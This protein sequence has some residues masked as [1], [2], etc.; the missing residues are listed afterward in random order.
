MT[1]SGDHRDSN[2]TVISLPKSVGALHGLLIVLM[3][4]LSAAAPNTVLEF[5]DFPHLPKTNDYLTSA[6]AQFERTHSGVRIHYTRLPWQDG[7]QKL[8]LS[9]LSGQPP[10]VCGQVSTGLP[11]FIAQ[12][13]LEPLETFLQNEVDDF[14]PDYLDAVSHNGHIYA[15]PW[16]KACYVMLLNLDLFEQFG[17][18]PPVDGRWTWDEFLA[19]MKA[20]TRSSASTTTIT[21]GTQPMFYGLVTNLGPMEYEAYSIIFNFGGR[22]LAED[23]FGK[24][25]SAVT[26]PA[27]RRGLQNLQDLEFVYHV[28]APGIGAMTQEQ[29]WNLWRDSRTCACTIQ[30]AWCVTAVERANEANEATNRRKAAAGRTSEMEKPIKWMIAAPPS[31]DA[32][33]TPV[34]GSSGLG[35]YVVF[36]QSDAERK[37]LAAEFALFLV[38]GEGQKVLRYENVYPSRK[39]SG[40]P[41]ADDPRLESVF[42]LF[43]AAIMSPL[44]PGGERIDRVLQ[45]EIQKAVLTDSATGRP[46]ATVEQATAAAESK[47]QA[48]LERAHRRF[49]A[50]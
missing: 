42:R 13:V 46:Q 14:Y 11:G 22:I 37:R 49:G 16:Y 24:I 15:V 5:W 3:A 18:A 33:T 30:G 34:L 2:W 26:R 27:F 32:N 4:G 28:A 7:Q 6:M 45:Q 25:G 31:V 29:S 48:V 35:T 9:V 39:S 47:I 50:L 41:F 21:S 23:G 17:V 10:D 12:D 36:K 1:R 38:S 43:P 44:I 19:K 8:T 40:N 20:L